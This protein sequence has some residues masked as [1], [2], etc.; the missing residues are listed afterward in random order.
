[1]ELEQ[2]VIFLEIAFELPFRGQMHLIYILTQGPSLLLG[3]C[4]HIVLGFSLIF[5]Y[6]AAVISYRP[7]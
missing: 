4:L 1:M 3:L 6:L 7:T 5:I 2:L